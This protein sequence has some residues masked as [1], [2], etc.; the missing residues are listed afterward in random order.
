MYIKAFN[1]DKSQNVLRKNHLPIVINYNPSKANR[2]LN[3]V[4]KLIV[5]PISGF[6]LGCIENTMVNIT[7]DIRLKKYCISTWMDENG[8]EER[9]KEKYIYNQ[10]IE[11]IK[12]VLTLGTEAN[13][14]EPLKSYQ[15]NNKE[16]KKI[17]EILDRCNANLLVNKRV[18]QNYISLIDDNVVNC[19][20]NNV[21]YSKRI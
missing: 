5:D 17:I 14:T 20:I 12:T 10:D 4:D 21:D 6:M 2:K 7:N 19:K 11:V 9:L 15:I 18:L 13:Q 3:S 1:F 8:S 16:K